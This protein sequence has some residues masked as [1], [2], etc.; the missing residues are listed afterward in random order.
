M[1]EIEPDESWPFTIG[2]VSDDYDTITCEL[3]INEPRSI[4]V[5]TNK[6]LL[7]VCSTETGIY[8]FPTTVKEVENDPMRLTLSLFKGAVHIQRR[9]Y[10][11]LSRPLVLMKYR[12]VVSPEDLFTN[13]L[14]DAPIKDLSG[15]GVSLII[16]VEDE[17]EPGTP[18]RTE[19]QLASGKSVNLVGEV[20][21]CITNEPINGRSLMCIYFS[22][23]EERDRDK[24]ISQLF[25]EQL[26]RAGK[27]RG[28][29]RR[30]T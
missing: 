24:I 19:M 28:L 29:N 23:I 13:E 27:R 9:E 20:I 1:I 26:T 2:S 16:P 4:K 12:P 6:E 8:R 11:R 30:S 22:L 25:R 3:M 18:I 7:V 14:K 17:V 5:D 15:N 10:F 21:R